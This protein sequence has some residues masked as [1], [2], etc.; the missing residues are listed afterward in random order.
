MFGASGVPLISGYHCGAT[1]PFGTKI[2]LDGYGIVE[3]Q[4]RPAEWV[5]QKFGNNLIDIYMDSHEKA[6]EM[7]CK[8]MTGRVINAEVY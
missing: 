6:C 7:A 8:Q 4:D 1:Y 5:T 2:E 3:V